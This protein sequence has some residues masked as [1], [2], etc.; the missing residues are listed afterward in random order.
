MPPL[1]TLAKLRALLA[2]EAPQQAEV[3]RDALRQ[4]A[5]TGREH[6]VIGLADEGGASA[7]T[8]GKVELRLSF[9]RKAATAGSQAL[10]LP[11]LT[12]LQ[13]L[14]GSGMDHRAD[15]QGRPQG[16]ATC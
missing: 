16:D 7:I 10:N 9:G 14:Q 13:R 6:S 11:L 2:R 3:I 1:S 5:Q 12:E 8:R 4:T 15:L